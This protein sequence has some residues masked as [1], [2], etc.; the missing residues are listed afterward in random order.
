MESII[1]KF[2]LCKFWNELSTKHH[3]HILEK[4]KTSVKSWGR[5]IYIC[6]HEA[7]G[8]SKT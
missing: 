8:D 7:A 3:R 2:H 6:H 1:T 4:N 5:M